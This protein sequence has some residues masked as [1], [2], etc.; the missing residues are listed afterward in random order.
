MSTGNWEQDGAIQRAEHIDAWDRL[1]FAAK[2]VVKLL[3][4]PKLGDAEWTRDLALHKTEASKA[5][6]EIGLPFVGLGH[7]LLN[8]EQP[9]EGGE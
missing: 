1:R 4:W 5:A 9:R 7:D 3:S 2:T 6:A 8:G